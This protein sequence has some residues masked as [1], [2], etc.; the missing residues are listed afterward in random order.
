MPTLSR[1]LAE[2]CASVEPKEVAAEVYE[3]I[4]ARL[5][6]TVGLIIAGSTTEAV[7]AARLMVE[8]LG[9]AARSTVI[10]SE[11]RLPSACAALVHGVAAHC[12][13]FDDTFTESVVHPGSVVIP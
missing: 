7:K 1:Q 3:D 4:P 5:L 8:G 13:D 9:G 12:H 10:G 2:W 6:D 11:T